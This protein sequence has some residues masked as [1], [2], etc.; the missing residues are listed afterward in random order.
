MCKPLSRLTKEKRE[1][2]Q[3][4]KVINGEEDITTDITKESKEATMDN[5]MP[6]TE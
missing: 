3:I 6:T 2:I 1:R 5:Y 4:N